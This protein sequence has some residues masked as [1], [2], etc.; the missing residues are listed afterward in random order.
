MADT[1]FNER[2]SSQ[3]SLAAR[4]ELPNG[5]PHDDDRKEQA[6]AQLVERGVLS[7]AFGRHG[8]YKVRTTLTTRQNWEYRCC[9]LRHGKAIKGAFFPIIVEHQ[10]PFQSVSIRLQGVEDIRLSFAQEAV[11]VHFTRCAALQEY[12]VL[13]ALYDQPLSPSRRWYSLLVP[14]IGIAAVAAYGFW[15][16]AFRTDS[17]Q[18]LD[19]PSLRVADRLPT[20]E[21]SGI[22]P[23]TSGSTASR[24]GMSEQGGTSGPI[25]PA[26]APKP[27]RLNDLIATQEPV[28]KADRA[29]RA[30]TPAAAVGSAMSDIQAG[31]VVLLTGWIHRVFRAPDNT[32]RLHVSPNRNSGAREL[33]A[34]VPPPDQAPDSSTLQ[35]QL[36][37]V[38]TFIRQQLFRQQEPSPRGSVIQRPIL[39]Q[40]IGRLSNPA[41]SLGAPAAGK[42]SKDTA[43]RWEISPVLEVRFAT[44]SQPADRSQ[45]Q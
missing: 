44:S 3:T 22:S 41:S 8:E 18:L 34:I 12:L 33:V 36:Q 26:E 4:P 40:L 32:Y 1:P 13:S 20:R 19:S 9:V 43:A 10:S 38:R 35:T 37:T 28:Q 30:V 11:D 14:L 7:H 21:L 29:S 24:N 25:D 5:Q 15:A 17:G 27:M 2:P 6:I 31:D 45:P 42:R 39:V 23:P 16:H